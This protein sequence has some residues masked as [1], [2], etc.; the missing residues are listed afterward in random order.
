[1]AKKTIV[2][3]HGFLSGAQSEKAVATGEFLKK[4]FPE[5]DFITDNFPNTPKESWQAVENL[6]K[7]LVSEDR[8]I[9]VIGSSMGGF[10]AMQISATY[11]FK[12]A[13]INPCVFPW[14]FIPVVIGEHTNPY[15]GVK[16]KIDASDADLTKKMAEG[17]APDMS[18]LAVY[19]CRGDEVLPY[20]LALD[21]LKDAALLHV[22]NG[23]NHLFPNYKN[24]LPEIVRFLTESR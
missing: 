7:K 11:G 8:E 13:L 24:C 19:L 14:H 1:M 22:E 12:A 3:F 2:Y 21:Y 20:K 16:F 15:T 23:G 4:N 18:R 5:I 9:S 6:V 10:Y 17:R